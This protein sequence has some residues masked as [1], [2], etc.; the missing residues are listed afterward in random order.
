L[1]LSVI[2]QAMLDLFGASD[3]QLVGGKSDRSW[4][5]KRAAEIRAEAE[6]FLL[7]QRGP[8]AEHRALACA[9]AGLEPEG[10]RMAAWKR[11]E[12]MTAPNVA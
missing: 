1:W 10:L 9:L 7:D 2:N 8:W 5:G 6:A 12:A 11:L 4:R 3:N